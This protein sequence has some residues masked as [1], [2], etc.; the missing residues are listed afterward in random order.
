MNQGDLLSAAERDRAAPERGGVPHARCERRADGNYIAHADAPHW[1]WLGTQ[2]APL[3]P[4]E[5]GDVVIDLLF[6]GRVVL[7]AVP[8]DATHRR[9]EVLR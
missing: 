1:L 2:R 4:D 9:V 3:R 5:H 7:S 8:G 6:G